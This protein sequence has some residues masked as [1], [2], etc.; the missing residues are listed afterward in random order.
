MDALYFN[1]IRIL[2]YFEI[3]LVID[4]FKVLRV[5]NYCLKFH[6][7]GIIRVSWI[8]MCFSGRKNTGKFGS[9][10]SLKGRT[11]VKSSG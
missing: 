2:K 1:K 8:N 4:A 6:N 3:W 9:Q 10:G 5:L 7:H 11:K